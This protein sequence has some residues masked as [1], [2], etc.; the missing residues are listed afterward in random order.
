MDLQAFTI[1]EFCEAFRLSRSGFYNAIARGEAPAL[2]RV[3]RRVMISRQ[4]AEEWRS[5]ITV[6]ATTKQSQKSGTG[7]DGRQ[8]PS[9]IAK[10]ADL[11]SSTRAR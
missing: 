2:M 1:A 10:P 6:A 7:D 5:K 9:T 8:E 4:S 3:G 11:N